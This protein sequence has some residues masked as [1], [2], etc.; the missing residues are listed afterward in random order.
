MLSWKKCK[1]QGE[2]SSHVHCLSLLGY[3]YML[4]EKWLLRFGE[5]ALCIF[6]LEIIEIFVNWGIEPPKNG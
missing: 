2:I 4:V 3:G 6:R 1:I 5:T